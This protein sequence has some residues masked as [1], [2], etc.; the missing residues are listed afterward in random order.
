MVEGVRAGVID[1]IVSS[2][3]PQAPETKRLP[4]AQAAYGAVG[5]ET[6]LPAALSLH[7]EG[8]MK[9]ID[10]LRCLTINPA[11]LLRLSAGRLAKGAPADLILF[12]PGAPRKIDPVEF[13]S[14]SKNSPFKGRL[15]QG[16]VLRTVVGGTTVFAG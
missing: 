2:H 9:L 16:R 10:V 14:R 12:D 4:F 5:L 13:R 3:D 7:H 11:K 8:G 15:M 1:A 6:L